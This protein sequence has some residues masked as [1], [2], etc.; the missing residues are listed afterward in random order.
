MLKNYG[1]VRDKSKK[2]EDEDV[3]AILAH[4]NG[5]YAADALT[6]YTGYPI[7]PLTKV[8]YVTPH[9]G[10]IKLEL[11]K[12]YNLSFTNN[13]KAGNSQCTLTGKG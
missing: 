3:R 4:L 9:E 7:T 5:D 6:A 10:T 13:I 1:R 2:G 11:G 8:V 12:D